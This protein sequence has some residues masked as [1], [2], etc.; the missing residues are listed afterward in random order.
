MSS[1]SVRNE[2][3]QD[4]GEPA[5]RRSAD[6]ALALEIMLACFAQDAKAARKMTPAP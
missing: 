5:A 4:P 2:A 6:T 1:A 3:R